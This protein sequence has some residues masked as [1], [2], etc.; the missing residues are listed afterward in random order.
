MEQAKRSSPVVLVVLVI[1]IILALVIVIKTAS[2][3]HKPKQ[4]V[5]DENITQMKQM[6]KQ[7][8]KE[9]APEGATPPKPGSSEGQ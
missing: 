5:T 8:M 7:H 3:M 1:V 4:A 6:Y 2:K 9:I